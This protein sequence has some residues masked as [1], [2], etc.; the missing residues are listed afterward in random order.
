M[1]SFVFCFFD[2][3]VIELFDMLV[4]IFVVDEGCWDMVVIKD[5]VVL[6]VLGEVIWLMFVQSGEMCIF[7]FEVNDL[8]VLQY[9]FWIFDV[10]QDECYLIDGGVFDVVGGQ[11]V[12]IIDVKI[13]V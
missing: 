7:G 8:D 13:E 12:V 5:L 1:L 11:V 4:V 2:C 10:E 3:M 9:Q 6:G